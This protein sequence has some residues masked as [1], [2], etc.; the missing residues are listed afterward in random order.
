MHRYGIGQARSG[1]SARGVEITLSFAETPRMK[2]FTAN[3]GTGSGQRGT[4]NLQVQ[5]DKQ[6]R[7]SFGEVFRPLD[8]DIV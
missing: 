4:N 3:G 1:S 5:D 7:S 2:Q 6:L 8:I